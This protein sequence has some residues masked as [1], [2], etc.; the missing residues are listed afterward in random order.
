[1]NW[2]FQNSE[3]VIVLQNVLS[4]RC[5]YHKSFDRSVLS[6]YANHLYSRNSMYSLTF[7][8]I[9]ELRIEWVCKS[10]RELKYLWYTFRIHDLNDGSRIII[11]EGTSECGSQIIWFRSELKSWFSNFLI[12]IRSLERISWIIWFRSELGSGLV[13]QLIYIETLERISRIFWFRLGLRSAYCELI[14][15]DRN[16]RSE[17]S[18]DLDQYR[19]NPK[20]ERTICFTKC[21]SFVGTIC[22]FMASNAQLRL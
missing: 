15:L 17:E 2:A 10:F 5:A 9:S 19:S 3:S 4:F 7:W 13:N 22:G 11:Q 16:F 14:D 6:A 1:M 8:V 20:L 21:V 18:F 12:Q